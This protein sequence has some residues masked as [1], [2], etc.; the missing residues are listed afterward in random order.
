MDQQARLYIHKALTIQE[1]N[2]H[3]LVQHPR[4]RS[5]YDYSIKDIV[6]D[7]QAFGK[8]SGFSDKFADQ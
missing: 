1:S 6:N 3:V 7:N 4:E 5:C 8:N 2:R